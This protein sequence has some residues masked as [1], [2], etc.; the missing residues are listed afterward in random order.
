MALVFGIDVAARKKIVLFRFV[1]AGRNLAQR[2]GVGIYEA[3]A[4]GDIARGSDTDKSQ[5]RPAGMRFVHAL[6]QLRQRVAYI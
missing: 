5:S 1:D 3:M 2:V 4:W 6:M